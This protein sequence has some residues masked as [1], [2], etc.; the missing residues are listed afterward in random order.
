MLSFSTSDLCHSFITFLIC[1]S[2]FWSI[3]LL[4]SSFQAHL[5]DVHSFV[6]WS[7]FAPHS[8]FLNIHFEWGFII[9]LR[10]SCLK[11]DHFS[12]I[13]IRRWAR[14]AFLTSW[15]QNSIIFTKLYKM[16]PCTSCNMEA[17]LLSCTFIWTSLLCL[18][19]LCCST[20]ILCPV[21]PAQCG[22]SS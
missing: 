9:V 8:I 15:F 20:W 11:C 13:L 5:Y 6:L 18:S 10:H 19:P 3:R 2:L 17:L 14:I 12:S 16:W 22:P 1:Y 4:F 21:V 7:L